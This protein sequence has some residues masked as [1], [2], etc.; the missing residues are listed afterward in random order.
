LSRFSRKKYYPKGGD[1]FLETK[2]DL[3]KTEKER[4]ITLPKEKGTHVPII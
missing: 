2:P 3:D 4:A 1:F